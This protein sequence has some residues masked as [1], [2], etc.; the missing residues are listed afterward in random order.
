MHINIIQKVD[1]IFSYL[2][3]LEPLFVSLYNNQKFVSETKCYKL[4]ALNMG[5]KHIQVSEYNLLSDAKQTCSE[6]PDCIGLDCGN[7]FPTQCFLLTENLGGGSI[8]HDRIQVW[9]AS[10]DGK[11]Y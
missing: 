4:S 1:L 5:W 10:C 9:K 2:N 3:V 7:Q 6:T 8:R 11:Y